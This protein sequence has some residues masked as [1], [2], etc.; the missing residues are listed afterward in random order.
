MNGDGLTPEKQLKNADA[1]GFG[2]FFAI[3]YVQTGET[4]GEYAFQRLC[5]ICLLI[6]GFCVNNPVFSKK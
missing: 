6:S 1:S 3:L 2:G 5:T 4:G